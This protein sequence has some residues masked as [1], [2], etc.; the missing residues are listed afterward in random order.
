M[1]R[2]LAEWRA[3]QPTAAPGP[4]PAPSTAALEADVRAIRHE[5]FRPAGGG[6]YGSGGWNGFSWPATTAPY[7]IVN[8][9]VAVKTADGR[10]SRM[11][12]SAQPSG[13]DNV[14]FFGSEEI[15]LL[16]S[17]ITALGGT[18]RRAPGAIMETPN[19]PVG[20]SMDIL[21]LWNQFFAARPG[22][23]GGWV[24]ETYPIA[25]QIEFTNAERTKAIVPVTIGYAGA[26]VMLEKRDGLWNAVRLVN[27]WVT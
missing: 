9:E 17:A 2:A 12:L 5:V 20:A 10:V 26:T 7:V 14:L 24:F 19:Q 1:T 21:S 15:S 22:H 23:W 13:F 3:H 4:P 18:K 16:N 27:R 8:P 6:V 25:G 11:M